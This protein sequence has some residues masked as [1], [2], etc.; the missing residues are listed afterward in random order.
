MVMLPMIVLKA[1]LIP[2]SLETV[3]DFFKYSAADEIGIPLLPV[4]AGC[5]VGL[6]ARQLVRA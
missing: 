5:A 6:V 1:P 3:V 4:V 2:D